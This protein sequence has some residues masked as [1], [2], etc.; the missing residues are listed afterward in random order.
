MKLYF[1]R[2]TEA[3][4]ALARSAEASE[5]RSRALALRARIAELGSD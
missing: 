3:L 2:H 1:L 4:D 5:S